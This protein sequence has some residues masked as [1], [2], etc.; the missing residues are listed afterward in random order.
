MS[1]RL[2]LLL[3]LA[4][5]LFTLH[6]LPLLPRPGRLLG[7]AVA[8]EIKSGQLG[9]RLLR[10][11][12]LYLLPWTLAALLCSLFLPLAWSVVW[13]LCA[14]LVPLVAAGLIFSGLRRHLLP[15]A[16]PQSSLRSVPL[17]G[18]D[19]RP[20]LQRWLFAVP[21]ISLLGVGI[22]LIENWDA[23]PSR[24]PI[25][26]DSNGVADGWSARSVAGVF[27][28]LLIGV[29]VILFLAVNLQL[30]DSTSRKSAQHP[31]TRI[32]RIAAAWVIGASFSLVGLLP[33]HSFSIQTIV[34][35]DLGSVLLVLGLV[36][37][38][39]SRSAG[40][41]DTG[42]LTPDACWHGD[43]FYYNPLDPA[44]FVEKRIGVGVTFN[45]G[46]RLSWLV[47]ALTI[48]IP[49]GLVALALRFTG[50]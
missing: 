40:S 39:A 18:S 15:F 36:G 7:L 20:A 44:L 29:L 24:F 26:F 5:I 12:E 22:Y 35:F 6:S 30:T 17:K 9:R 50:K 16:L 33:L 42:E 25:H 1:T 45:F 34:W 47:L 2:F 19:Q 27:G 14:S 8:P 37:L 13:I 21:L 46:N 31:A 43:Q 23:I 41:A 32:A 3:P 10:T 49:V 48:L 38:T 28:P 4:L 11:Y